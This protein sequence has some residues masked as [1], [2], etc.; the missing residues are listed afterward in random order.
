MASNITI[1]TTP[2]TYSPVYNPIE[3]CVYE[4]DGVSRA[5]TNYKY[6]ITCTLSTGEED[7]W[8]VPL[9]PSDKLFYGWQDVSRFLEKFI[10]EK[11]VPVTT[12]SGFVAAQST[13]I[14]SY[15]ISVLSGWDVSGT[16][17]EDPDG[18]GA[19]TTSTL[20]AWGASFD[21]H[22]WI[23]Q[24]NDANPYN[25]WICNATNGTSAKFLT[26]NPYIQAR[27]TDLGRI[28]I[29]TDDPGNI[30]HLLIKTYDS[31]D[32]LLGSFVVDNPLG[33]TPV[34]NRVLSIA[35][36]PQSINNINNT[37]ISTGSQTIIGSDVSYYT[38][39]LDKTG[40]GG[41]SS[42]LLTVYLQEDCRYETYR[43]HFL[44]KFGSFDFFNFTSRNELK[45]S[46]TRKTYTRGETVIETDGIQYANWNNGKSDYYVQNRDSLKLRSDYVTADQ[47]TWLKELVN[48]PLVFIEYSNFKGDK[49]FK[50][51]YV[52]TTN[53]VEKKTSIDKLFKFELDVEF[54][55]VNQRQRR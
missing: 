8:Q 6:I 3:I 19:V 7:T 41:I 39:Q 20:Y 11:L 17:T 37:Y 38:L 24:V 32:T 45:S 36:A 48:S 40:A 49:D 15:T 25:T 22:D 5:E 34:A 52:T 29:L 28:N 55:H 30:D 13:G 33:G 47:Y 1:K 54:G 4:Q 2:A 46:T 27:L 10:K 14:V 50:P 35:A 31:D 44:N 21:H 18:V 12:D 53:W 9:A 26:N 43:L 23:D 42:E 16:F 51:V